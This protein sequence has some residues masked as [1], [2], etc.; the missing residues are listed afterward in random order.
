MVSPDDFPLSFSQQQL[1]LID[2]IHSVGTAYTLPLCWRLTGDLDR[3][4]LHTAMARLVE[5]HQVLRTR[6]ESRDGIARQVI[7]APGEPDWEVVDLS[8]VPAD[9]QDAHWRELAAAEVRRPFDLARQWP[10]RARLFGLSADEHVFMLTV[11]HIACDGWSIGVLN[12]D[13]A[14]LYRAGVAGEAPL[15]PQLPTQYAEFAQRQR[16]TATESRLVRDLEY[17]KD[18]LSDLRPAELPTDR[19][20]PTA[21]D[22]S[23]ATVRFMIAP[24]I[25]R[26]LLSLGRAQG[27]T[28]YMSLLS[29]FFVLLARWARHPQVAVGTPFAGR[30]QPELHDLMGQFVNTAVIRADADPRLSFQQ[31]LRSVRQSCLSAYGHQEV[32]FEQVVAEVAPTRELA[33]NPLFQVMFSVVGPERGSLELHGLT[34]TETCAPDVSPMF[35]LSVEL[36]AGPD[37]GYAGVLT[38]SSALFEHESMQ[39]FAEAFERLLGA[40]V[41]EPGIPV[42]ELDLLGEQARQLIG[43]WN[44]TASPRPAAGVHDLVASQARRT[45]DAPAVISSAG[46]LSYAELDGRANGLAQHLRGLGV[47]PESRIGVCL[48]RGV[49]LIVGL[50]AVLKC[51][52]AYVP[53]NPGQPAERNAL[54]LADAGV[55]IVLADHRWA[56]RLAPVRVV[57]P[58]DAGSAA[59]A[60]ANHSAADS[61]IYVLYTSGSTG[62]PKGV[63][64]THRGMVNRALWGAER[65]LVPGD[66]VLHKTALTFDA[67]GWEIWAP[68]VAGA[69]IVLAEPEAER[70]PAALIHDLRG[71]GATVVQL[72]PSML[73]LLVDEPSFADCRSLRSIFCGGEPLS[74]ELADQVSN[75]LTVELTNLYGP[76]ECTIDVTSWCYRRGE[77]VAIGAP[78]PNVEVHVLDE[79]SRPVPLGVAGELYVGGHGLA[80]GY[81]GRAALTAERFVPDPFGDG[82]RLYRTGDH[83]RWRSDGNLEFLGRLDDQVKIGGV[84]IELGEVEA[85]VAGHPA[86]TGVAALALTDRRGDKYLVVHYEPDSIDDHDLRAYAESRLP[87]AMVASIFLASKRLPR[88]A[89]GKVDR[90]TLATVA[91]PDEVGA[92]PACSVT[93]KK[94]AAVLADAL[95]LALIG[96]QDDFFRLGGHSLLAIRTASALRRELGVDLPAR[97]IFEAPTVERIVRRLENPVTRRATIPP[98]PPG[99][100]PPASSGQQRIWFLDRLRPDSSDYLLALAVRIRGALDVRA[101]TDALHA[102]IARHEVLRTRFELRDGGLKQVICP[103][104]AVRMERPSLTATSEDDLVRFVEQAA[105]V[106]FALDTEVPL[107]AVLADLDGEDH[108]LVLVLNHIACDARSMEVLAEDLAD[109]YAHRG[110]EPLPVRFADFAAWE[111]EWLGSDEAA[112]QLSFWRDELAGLAALELAPEKGECPASGDRGGVVEFTVPAAQARALIHIGRQEGATPFLTMLAAFEVVLSRLTGRDDFAVGTTVSG[113]S[114]PSVE[115]LV[116]PF[117]NSVVLRACL[118]G[119]A[120][121]IDVL[122]QVQGCAQR[123]FA[124]QELPFDQ[125]VGQLHPQRDPGRNPLFNVL[126]ELEPY[127]GPRIS[128]EGLKVQ[129][130]PVHSAAAKLDLTLH[131]DELQDGGYLATIEYARAL[132]D[133]R[134][135]QGIAELFRQV[136]EDGATGP[137]EPLAMTTAAANGTAAGT[138]QAAET[139]YDQPQTSTEETVADIWMDVLDLDQVDVNDNFFDLGGHSLLAIHSQASI[140]DEFGIDLPLRTLFEAV[141]VRELAKVIDG[142]KSRTESG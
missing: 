116:G 54:M 28:P 95:G 72:V 18:R 80:R 115:R 10:L 26:D 34:A 17:W 141:T 70:D 25:S 45:P 73:R 40:A 119:C 38:Y 88:T 126:F 56:E 37:A 79:Q 50:L 112:R 111:Q 32:P 69:A 90:S 3:G 97:I 81:L 27:A 92:V 46:Q 139:E 53:L 127:A 42:G 117:M 108:L 64:I 55:A 8:G 31:V 101:L 75:L 24:E 29:A 84:R 137:R 128:L 35:D 113:R 94:V 83:V 39:R 132:L 52:G 121:F 91:P 134:S 49:D 105:R 59:T 6:Y 89:G 19:P 20:R 2:Q 30:T 136:I 106:P 104:E 93:E 62:K 47:G 65:H 66:R 9:Q 100:A 77:R 1:W 129:E 58:Q 36:T 76:T 96:M 123:A 5:R 15:L 86:V 130:I 125:L 131:L 109:L 110:L 13:V 74:A 140:Q 124:N 114:H 23:G 67:A 7:D 43:D 78:L 4:V 107:R 57:S 99:V 22:P 44:Q 11:H 133:G 142:M 120:T 87:A 14:E 85:V 98:V 33:R 61:L 71:H 12:R 16:S 51:G 82:G 68:L 135:V 102:V 103:P 48:P 118:A 21:W 60:P 138:Q 122:H 41:A 63:L